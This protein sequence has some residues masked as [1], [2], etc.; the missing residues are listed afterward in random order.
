ML[1]LV[2]AL[3]AAAIYAG[4][5][6]KVGKH[7]L[8]KKLLLESLAFAAVSHVV[9]WAYRRYFVEDMTTFGDTCPNGYEMITDPANSNQ[10]TCV[11]VGHKTASASTGF[12]VDPPK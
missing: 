3:L 6:Y 8:D 5:R 7:R 9:M 10:Q 1:H 4:F 12:R 11:A 2:P